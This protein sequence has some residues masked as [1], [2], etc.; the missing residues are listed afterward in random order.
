M[1]ATRTQVAKLAKVSTCTVS[2]VLNNTRPVSDDLRKRV[3]DAVEE[4]SYH[5]NL[6]AKSLITKRS[7]QIAIVLDEIK[8]PH[9]STILEILNNE[10]RNQGYAVN[11]ILR[12]KNF[13]EDVNQLIS[14]RVDGAF[15]MVSPNRYGT[16]QAD[17]DGI[18]MLSQ[19]GIHT[20]IG[21]EV[22]RVAESSDFCSVYL[23]LSCAIQMAVEHL[24]GLGHRHIGLVN[25]FPPDYIYDMRSPTFLHTMAEL[26]GDD[27]PALSYGEPPYPGLIP[28]G[29]L[30]TKQLLSKRPETTAII[31]T[32]ES[33]AVGCVSQ[34]RRLGLRVPEDISVIS[35]GNLPINEYYTPSI[36]AVGF[37]LNRYG[38]EVF[39]QMH[40]SGDPET[41]VSIA[42]PSILRLGE[43][44][45]PP[46]SKKTELFPAEQTKR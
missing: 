43:T 38:A 22:P 19:S 44:T 32:N 29:M 31:A 2:N 28:D 45:I 16:A 42:I 21:F 20:V 4:L 24:K 13:N 27:S 18:R 10:A 9:Q 39:K 1:N 14:R 41:P 30:Y 25:F 11:I 36:T 23:D 33:M 35:V 8:D 17:L 37:D 46:T 7:Y 5:P 12:S 26:F 3:M 34:I 15:L 40:L 6:I